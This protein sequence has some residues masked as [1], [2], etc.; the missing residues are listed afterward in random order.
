VRTSASCT[1][2]ADAG[3]VT[4]TQ[5]DLRQQ[6]VAGTDV[7]DAAAAKETPRT[8]RDFPRLVELLARQAPGVAQRAAQAV[9]QTRSGKTPEIVTRQT[10][11]G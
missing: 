9:E 8:P 7:N 4:S 2:Q 6:A 10:R 3:T 1:R 11:A 5:H